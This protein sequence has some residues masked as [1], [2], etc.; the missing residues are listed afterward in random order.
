M[1]F[2][3]G[4]AFY[5]KIA[6]LHKQRIETRFFS[7]MFIPIFPV[8]SVFVTSAK[9]N[10]RYGIDI[11]L[12]KKSVFATYCRMFCLLLAVYMLCSALGIGH[13]H[14]YLSFEA[15]RHTT[16]LYFLKG[17]VFAAF[18]IY[19]YFF[20]GQSTAE[21]IALR[22]KIGS[23]TGIYALPQWFNYVYLKNMLRTLQLEYKETYPGSNWKEDLADKAVAPQKHAV[24]YALALFNCMVNDIPENDELYAIG[25]KLYNP[26]QS[27][28]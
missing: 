8:G 21:Q 16:N 14:F 10:K 4:T 11:P 13:L 22:N 9:F 17:A 25:D 19:F 18:Y 12:S 3:Y 26:H 27:N 2:V 7:L 23:V 5:G 24:L 1:V 15:A 6:P 28:N 20:F